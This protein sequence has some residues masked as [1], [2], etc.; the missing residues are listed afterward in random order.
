M[1]NMVDARITHVN[2]ILI[3]DLKGQVRTMNKILLAIIGTIV[4][5]GFSVTIAFFV[6]THTL[7]SMPTNNQ[8]G[9]TMSKN[10]ENKKTYANKQKNEKESVSKKEEKASESELSQISTQIYSSTKF[11]NNA[12]ADY[13]V[14]IKNNSSNHFNGSFEITN[15]QTNRST[16][17]SGFMELDPHEVKIIPCIGGV[18][19]KNDID[20]KLDGDFTEQEFKIDSS[21]NYTIVKREIN[22]P[23]SRTSGS[24]K[25]FIYIAP[26]TS[27]DMIISICKEIKQN[28]DTTLIIADFSPVM[29]NPVKN[30]TRITFAQ[31]KIMKFS[32]ILFYTTDTSNVHIQE[33]ERRIVDI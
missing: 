25:L 21:L 22:N 1:S 32:H 10:T 6:T 8:Q 33:M 14:L 7:S 16:D 31:N 18:P 26:N 30:D 4:V 9:E 3:Y 20:I 11:D 27:D 17:K 15:I 24:S 23:K 19:N 5:L 12:T 13:Y 29:I 2:Y 28:Y